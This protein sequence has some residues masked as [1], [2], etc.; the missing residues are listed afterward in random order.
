MRKKKIAICG[1]GYVGLPLGIRFAEAGIQVIGLDIDESKVNSL[2]KG[3]SYIKNIESSQLNRLVK[4]RNFYAS[5]DFSIIA[6]VEAV[7]IC[8][9]TPLGSHREP[10][11]S[12]VLSTGK[13]IAPFLKRLPN[14]LKPLVVL[15]STTYPGTTDE[16]LRILLEKES[17]LLAG[18]DF[19]LAYSPEREDPGS[20]E[21]SV[22]T[23][24]KVMG[25][26]TDE[27]L[28]RCSELYTIA[29]DKIHT[30]SSTRVA[31]ATK[32]MENIFRA[33]NIA[34]VNE[35]KIVYQ[36]M[37]IDVWEVIEAASTKPFGY[38]PFYPG[39]GLGEHCIPIDPFYLTWKAK[40]YNK[41]SKF[42]EL[43]GEINTEMPFYVISKVFYALN[44]IN[45]SIKD[46]KI[47][48]LGLA[49]KKNVDDYRESPSL[50]LWEILE[51]LGAQV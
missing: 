8:V 9:P 39:P 1:L 14:E 43:A 33:V 26:L 12:Y 3:L 27:C 40:E 51:E 16:D 35:L 5:K 13:K 2:N 21:H 31:E 38:M 44:R 28:R 25:G 37:G 49:Y 47:L 4:E 17:G 6:Q 18:K 48:I 32:L 45:K 30:V 15:E 42:I 11:I 7:L 24:P 20:K 36:A 19:H 34:L 10:D 41:H 46:T 22:R 23:I 29:I 50:K